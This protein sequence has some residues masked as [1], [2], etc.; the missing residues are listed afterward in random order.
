[1]F[2]NIFILLYVVQSL[3]SILQ[4]CLLHPGP[5]LRH[6]AGYRRLLHP[7]HRVQVREGCTVQY[8]IVLYFTVLYCTVLYCR[9]GLE[10]WIEDLPSLN[11][12]RY[13]HGCGGY[14]SDGDL[15]SVVVQALHCCTT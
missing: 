14:V 1:M 9:Y 6:G 12:G 11:V 8:S 2:Y 3:I 10:G 5:L 4:S 15:V 13:W 7:E